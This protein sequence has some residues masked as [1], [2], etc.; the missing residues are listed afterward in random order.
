MPR[1]MRLSGDLKSVLINDSS[2]LL[3]ALCAADAAQTLCCIRWLT[4]AVLITDDQ[5]WTFCTVLLEWVSEHT[6]PDSAV[7]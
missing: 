2:L 7:L 5:F 1:Y 3:H 4:S 6:T